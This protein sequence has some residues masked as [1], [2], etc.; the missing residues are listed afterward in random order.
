MVG[1]EAMQ[2]FQRFKNRI[3]IGVCENRVVGAERLIEEAGLQALVL[4]DSYQHRAI[5]AGFNILLTDYSDPYFSDYLLPAGNLRESR[6]GADRADIIMVTKCPKDLTEEKKF[7][8]IS[9]IK[10]KKHQKVFFSSI[11]YDEEITSTK[12]KM[13]VKMLDQ[14]EVLLIT[15]I[16]NPSQLIKEVSKYTDKIKHLRFRDHY[17][18]KKEDIDKML[19]EYKKLGEK[20]L[21]LTTEKD[22]VRLMDFEELTDKLFYW[23]I[24]VEINNKEEF[25]QIILN[26]VRENQGNR[27]FH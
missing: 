18:F 10:P 27:E 21:I 17:S 16:A 7:Y 24:N 1:D 15:G 12:V 8:Y 9:K 13:P 19:Q 3:A 20:K 5:Q 11:D 22:Y 26:Y 4:D 25:N 2:L 14:Y 6:A 23:P